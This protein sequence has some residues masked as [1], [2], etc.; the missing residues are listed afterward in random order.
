MLFLLIGAPARKSDFSFV[1]CAT[2][3]RERQ[4]ISKYA[5]VNSQHTAIG[6]NDS[7][8]DHVG[9]FSN[10]AGPVIVRK[11]IEGFAIDTINPFTGA[12]GKSRH[13]ILHQ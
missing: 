13:K 3:G 2:S 12:L 9:Q 1:R 8:L 11:C 10:I 6:Q 4:I 7:A 5:R